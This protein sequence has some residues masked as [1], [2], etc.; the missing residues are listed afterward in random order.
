[1]LE[2]AGQFD[3]VALRRLARHL[4]HV[5]D[6][7]GAEKALAEQLSKEEAAAAAKASLHLYDDGKGSR[8]GQFTIP[9]VHGDMLRVALDALASPKRPDAI[10]REVEEDGRTA[11]RPRPEVRGE[12]FTQL[13]ERFP[14][15][16]LPRTGGGLVTVL[17]TIPLHVLE[18]RLGVGT[19]STGGKITEGAARRLACQAGLIPQVLGSRSEV[20]DQGRR[21]R[22]HTAGQ[23]IAMASRD[24]TCTATGCTVPASFCHAHHKRPWAKGGRTSVADGTML[25]PRHHHMVHDA[26]YTIDYRSDGSTHITRTSRRRH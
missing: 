6:P 10:V 21:V 3:A 7:E 8:H 9:S 13:L 26:R 4:H 2:L 23:R 11:T 25:C 15:R 14:T 17:V 16:K 12:A 18:E 1:L 19:L 5:I 20:L 22:L 24:R